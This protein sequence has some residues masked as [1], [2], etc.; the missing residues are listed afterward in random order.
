[1]LTSTRNRQQCNN[2]ERK[3][4]GR[5]R[6]LRDSCNIDF[7]REIRRGIPSSGGEF[8]YIIFL[9]TSLGK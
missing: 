9:L 3:K 6:S 8:S 2:R 7:S 4:D 1:M 5:K